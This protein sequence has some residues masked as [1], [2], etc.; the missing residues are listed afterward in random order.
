MSNCIPEGLSQLGQLLLV[1][2]LSLQQIPHTND[3]TSVL[4]NGFTGDDIFKG[5]EGEVSS[6][7]GANG[8]LAKPG[9]GPCIIVISANAFLDSFVAVGLPQWPPAP[10]ASERLY[11]VQKQ[12]ENHTPEDIVPHSFICTAFPA[13]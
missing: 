12:G 8:T 5:D 4:L 7:G 13:H 3:F 10:L 2:S 6:R 1:P 11:A 9:P